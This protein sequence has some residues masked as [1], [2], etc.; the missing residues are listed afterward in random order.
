M[1]KSIREQIE[2]RA[3]N[4][5]EV[6]R[7]LADLQG[8]NKSLG[9]I[10]R[11]NRQ[12]LKLIRAFREMHAAG[13]AGFG[14]LETLPAQNPYYGIVPCTAAGL[15]FVMMHAS[16]DVVVKRYLWIGPDGYEPDMVRCW[17][18]WCRQAGGDV[19]DI[20]AYSGLMS[21]LAAKAHRD[22]TV[23]LFE[24][25]DSVMERANT[26]IRL[27]RLGPRITRH[28][29]AASDE[30]GSQDIFMY[31][32]ANF[33]ST[34]SSLTKKPDKEV[35][36]TKTI[37]RVSLD[38]S[39]AELAPKVVKID[40]EGHELA[41]LRGMQGLIA[42]HKPKIMI[43]VWSDTRGDVLTFLRAQGYDLERVETVEATVNNYFAEP[44]GRPAQEG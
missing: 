37:Q 39:F 27:N 2:E 6:T 16:D 4:N 42:R 26:N 44:T 36:L 14:H 13:E 23:H 17:V 18:S 34:G 40:V 12:T 8:P 38:K 31:R 9:T 7:S 30:E 28:N 24:P 5:P 22:N 21:I 35:I 20:G 15:D 25:L 1:Q 41:V 19:L 11:R 32:N 29:L 3:E 10:A 43:E 33:L